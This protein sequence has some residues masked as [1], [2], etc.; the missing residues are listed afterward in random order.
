MLKFLVIG[1]VILAAAFL[2]MRAL[3]R[4]T[5]TIEPKQIE[6]DKP[7]IVTVDDGAVTAE[8]EGQ[9]LEIDPALLDEVRRLAEN[10]QA[11]EAV[12]RL[13]EATGMGLTEAKQIVDSLNRLHPK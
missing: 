10:G 12:K 11:I 7:N 8:V 6:R 13:R 1:L 2:L 5:R 9:E 4:R 3:G